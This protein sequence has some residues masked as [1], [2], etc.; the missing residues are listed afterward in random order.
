MWYRTIT[1]V[2]DFTSR[3]RDSPRYLQWWISLTGTALAA[4]Q[5]ESSYLTPNNHMMQKV[6]I[7]VVVGFK[8]K[9][10]LVCWSS[11]ASFS[12]FSGAVLL[13]SNSTAHMD[14]VQASWLRFDSIVIF[15]VSDSKLHLIIMHSLTLAG[16]QFEGFKRLSILSI[17]KCGKRPSDHRVGDT[18]WLNIWNRFK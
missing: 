5:L 2:R 6:S 7:I 18:R 12:I 17:R 16:A 4:M 13:F 10:Q 11:K 1:V 14:Y 8:G 15:L 9:T 3:L